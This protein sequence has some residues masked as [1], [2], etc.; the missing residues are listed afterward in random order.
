M[1]T[2]SERAA[3]DEVTAYVE[4][5]VRFH[6]DRHYPGLHAAIDGEP[7]VRLDAFDDGLTTVAVGQDQLSSSW[8][9]AVLGF[10]LAQFA[11]TGLIDN[12][13]VVDRRLIH[14]PVVADR[15][16]PTVHVVTT[17]ETGRIVGYVALVGSDDDVPLPLDDPGRSRFPVEVAHDV[18]LLTAHAAPGRTTHGVWEIK[19]FVKDRRMARGPQ[20]DR[21]PWHLIAG[22][23]RVVLLDPANKVIVGDSSERG[24]L[25][26][27]RM[28]GMDT[29]IVEGTEP[30]L[31]RT[32][33]M[34]PSY[35]LPDT[36]RAKPFVG[37]VTPDASRAIDTIERALRRPPEPGWTRTATRM[38][39]ADRGRAVG[40][41]LVSRLGRRD[42][43]GG[44]ATSG[45]VRA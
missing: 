44:P 45:E 15:G 1:T 5:L 2:G 10:R 12:R 37:V 41:R 29:A 19:R 36:V 43:P 23:G 33:L 31:P 8:L 6:G 27:L 13:L 21:V 32:E 9:A 3:A 7:L 28:V 16:V 11:T 4:A 40:R 18:D 42:A 20:R 35:E 26:H 17:T 30:S 14:E 38:L 25:R 22:M 24:A 34:W 39:V